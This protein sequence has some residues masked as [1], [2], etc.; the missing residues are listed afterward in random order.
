MRVSANKF[1]Y[2]VAGSVDCVPS[3]G[4]EKVLGRDSGVQIAL[5][6]RQSGA[7]FFFQPMLPEVAASDLDMTHIVNHSVF[8][9]DLVQVHHVRP[10]TVAS[11]EGEADAALF[12]S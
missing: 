4:L 9:R 11:I 3:R 2:S 1:R 6:N 7:S 5:I 12:A 10:S 8:S